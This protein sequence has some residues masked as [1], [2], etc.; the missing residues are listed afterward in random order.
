MAKSLPG[1]FAGPLAVEVESWRAA[2]YRARRHLDRKAERDVTLLITGG[3]RMPDDFIKA[4]AM[5]ADGIALA[6]SAIQAVGCVAARIC[7]PNNCPSDVATQE[8]QLRS[9]LKVNERAQRLAAF[10]E[11][12]TKLM[13]VM[14]RAC[15]HH[16]LA[17]FRQSDLT[18]WKREMALLSGVAFGAEP[19]ES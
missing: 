12:S 1:G 2:L 7:H 3:L 5:G 15:G 6:N 17:K 9:R 18:T 8:P 14:A 11:A 10:L 16:E 19:A 13:Q 4:L